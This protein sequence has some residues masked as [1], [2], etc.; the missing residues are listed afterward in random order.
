MIWDTYSLK[1]ALRV[2][3]AANIVA[4]GVK[5]NSQDVVEGDLFIALSGKRDGHEFVED[6]IARGA[7]CAIISKEVANIDS[8]K[9]IKVEDTFLA[10]N[11]LSEYKRS[12][13]KAK[14]IAITGSVGKTSTREAI[15]L[16]LSAYGKTHASIKSFNNYLGVPLTLA[17]MPNDTEY[18]VIEMG[19]NA[20]G[21]IRNLTSMVTPDIAV[22]TAI[23]E[24][25]I[26]FFNSV[27]E[28]ADAKCEIFEGVD[29]NTGTAIINRD[30]SAYERCIENIDFIGVMNVQTFGKRVDSNV[31]FLSYE[32]LDNHSV[33]LNFKIESEDYEIVM[34]NISMHLASNFAAGFAVVRALDL[35]IEKALDAIRDFKPFIGRGRFIEVKRK[36]N[37]LG[38]I[39]DYYNSNPQSLKASLEYLKQFV[40]NRKAAVIGDMAELGDRAFD[41]H[42]S[43]VSFIIDSG[44]SKLFLVGQLASQI[45]DSFPDSIKVKSYQNTDQIIADSENS[46]NDVDILL[47]KGSRGVGLE[48]LAKNLRVE[49]VL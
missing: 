32:L 10:L 24:G 16:M 43:L 19:M 40:S 22:I 18:A 46:F 3:V 2:K 29:I 8:E 21:E 1:K 33:R 31:R 39:C 47:I 7:S 11:N 30:M 4:N 26:Q 5:F 48:K 20:S 42:M 45:K 15:K 12:K 41:L 28:I 36:E 13:V 44:I 17:S 6:A 49:N 37:N 23:S 14:Y 25:H 38:I 35:E 27:E 34:P 9:L